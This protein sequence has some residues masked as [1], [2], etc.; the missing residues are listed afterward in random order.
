VAAGGF[1][2]GPCAGAV[3]SVAAGDGG[4]LCGDGICCCPKVARCALNLL[5]V[6]LFHTRTVGPRGILYVGR[7]W[8]L[9]TSVWG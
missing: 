6:R 3:G 9:E 1:G 5:S 7:R 4:W 2:G 8:T